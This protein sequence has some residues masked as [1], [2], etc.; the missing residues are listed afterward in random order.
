MNGQQVGKS[1]DKA[2]ST[3]LDC[4]LIMCGRSVNWWDEDIHQ[5]VKDHRAFFAQGLGRENTWE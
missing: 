4:K 5:F 2:A 1:V 3:T